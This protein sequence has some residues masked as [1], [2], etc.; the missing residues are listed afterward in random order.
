M[1]CG[2]AAS[3]IVVAALAAWADEP[4]A[5][6][7]LTDADRSQ[8]AEAARLNDEVMGLIRQGKAR[9]ALEPARRALEVRSKIEGE[10]HAGFAL[11]L[12]TLAQVRYE[13]GE[14]AT[15]KPLF[16][17]ALEIR[18]KTVGER[19]AVYLGNLNDLAATDEA[20]GDFAAAEKLYQRALDLRRDVLGRKH[21]DYATSLNNLGL[22]YVETG[23]YD[24]A[25]PL[26]RE[27]LELTKIALGEKHPDYAGSLNSLGGVYL[28]TGD[29]ARAEP[30]FRQAV[31][32]YKQVLG[33]KHPQYAESLGNLAGLYRA[34]G[35]CAAAEP[36]Y[37]QSA[38]ILKQTLGE[39]HPL[40]ATALHNL[41]GLYQQKGEFAKAA[42]IYQQ[43]LD[44]TAR[45][46]GEN[47]P[48]YA[49]TLDA[50]A[51]VTM[52]LGERTKAEAMFRRA[53][54]IR[55]KAL[56]DSH[57]DYA[58]SLNNLADVYRE[59]GQFAAAEP[60]LKQAIEIYRRAVGPKHP[61]Y[62]L[63]LSNLAALY[64]QQGQFAKA[65]PLAREALQT[66]RQ[67]L[68]LT[69]AVQSERQQLKMIE[70]V[71][72]RLDNY[73]AIATAV[74]SPPDESYAEVLAWKGSV[75][76]RQQRIRAMQNDLDHNRSPEV[77]KLYSEL[78]DASRAFANLSMAVPSPEDRDEYLR[79]L[80]ESSSRVER[81]EQSLAAASRE[82]RGQL[83]E[84]RQSAD[85]VR[86]ALPSG[87]ALVDLLEYW[88]LAPPGDR[89][90][91]SWQRCLVAFVVRPGLPVAR[92][93]L[94]SM[95]PITSAI[96]SW[97]K[98]V[99]APARDRLPD[100]AT[101]LR[102]LVWAKLEP[103]IG[104]AKLVLLSPD[105]ATA[106]FPWPALPGR[107][108]GSY[109]LEETAIVILPIPR[110]LPELVSNSDLSDSAKR[111]ALEPPSLLLV[112]DVDF[113]AAPVRA[114]AEAIVQMAPRGSRGAELPRWA[115][116]PGTRT[117]IV[118]IADSFSE[119]FPQGDLTKLRND[120]ATKRAVEAQLTKHRYVHFATHGFF[121]PA[122]P[123][124]AGLDPARRTESERFDPFGSEGVSGFHP[125][126]LSG[127]VLA[128]ANQPISEG[129]D[130][131]I[132]TA[133]EVSQL[134]LSH[135]E[136]AALSACETGLGTSAGGEGLLGLERAFQVSGAKAV[137]ATLWTIN[138]DA[139]RALMID[140]YD[141][142]WHKKMSKVESLRQAQLK[143][144]RE[145]ISRGL[146]F[147]DDRPPDKDRRLPP[148][149]WGAFTLS[150]DWR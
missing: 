94:G 13:L 16:E 73:L 19:H 88:S 131:G 34:T 82:F 15:A 135:V 68:D 78:D 49:N 140:F 40:C 97:R 26:L 100:P 148:Y 76:A 66:S 4:T 105:G 150:G 136:L 25:A 104:D 29:Y 124:P 103:A 69:A 71:R 11:G 144:L 47:H 146:K 141:N 23:S 18:R 91:E 113:D 44:I 22:L 8:L 14:Y 33:E 98:S 128:G 107:Q 77:A 101:E 115:P 54:E 139:S 43:A 58:L 41:A 106:R 9:E 42:P 46:V 62:V 64:R 118:A 85:D 45:T 81:L 123:R 133:L 138:D 132:L 31:E 108:P 12:S 57:A 50:L 65:A 130:D 114:P 126:L 134:D 111:N 122:Q 37:R 102:R 39:N 127:L 83:V 10:Q 60:L 32:L 61:L 74:Q 145:G 36:L 80:A 48:D 28:E 90:R 96:E 51:G 7:T 137:V 121:A 55:R 87:A 147:A 112:G 38:E 79:K 75:S 86:R 129:N 110:L 17:Q 92:I 120:Q 67:L 99:G 56:G 6:K 21:P 20:L 3:A 70:Q 52:S 2:V 119:R 143:M 30:L 63:S 93:E 72:Y 84:R 35:D 53:L 27:A 59:S 125:G 109:L 95:A 1:R 116:L 142:L 24:K 89:R 149:Y 5:R 117:E